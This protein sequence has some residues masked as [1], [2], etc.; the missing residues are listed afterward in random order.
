MTIQNI[1]QDNTMF[2]MM[3]FETPKTIN[4]N[5]SDGLGESSVRFCYAAVGLPSDV[6]DGF[7]DLLEA[8]RNVYQI[9]IEQE[10]ASC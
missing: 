6:I 3:Y 1:K 7:L 5:S 9:E 4:L 10:I 2:E 8:Y